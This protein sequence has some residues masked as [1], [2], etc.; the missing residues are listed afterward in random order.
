MLYTQERQC[1]FSMLSLPCPQSQEE[2]ITDSVIVLVSEPHQSHY[3]GLGRGVNS[4]GL[5]AN[6]AACDESCML[7]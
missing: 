1:L 4:R 6:E 5:Y 2:S 7:Q 3:Q